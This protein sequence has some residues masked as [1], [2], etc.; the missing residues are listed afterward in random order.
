MGGGHI[1][2]PLC[3][4]ASMLDFAVTVVDDRIAF[5]NSERFPQAMRVICNSFAAGI[6]SLQIRATDYVCVI[7][8]GHRWDHW[9]FNS[10]DA[11]G[12]ESNAKYNNRIT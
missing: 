10:F 6:E 5:A 2:V 9:F 4:M 3:A 1:A 12:V 7:T 8:R 11:S